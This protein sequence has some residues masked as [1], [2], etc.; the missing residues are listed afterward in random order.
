MITKISNNISRKVNTLGLK[1]TII[2]LLQRLYYSSFRNKRL[3]FTINLAQYVPENNYI[4][5]KVTVSPKPSFSQLSHQEKKA[6]RSH[7][8]DKLLNTFARRLA[9]GNKLFLLY[10]NAK[11]AGASWVYVGGKNKFFIVPLPEK[12]FIILDVFTI[13]KYRRMGTATTN[14][15]KILENMKLQGFERAFISTKEWNFYQKSI[16]KAGFELVGKYREFKIFGQNILI[17]SSD[18]ETNF[19]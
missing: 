13:D 6:L 7:G 19:R 3:F 16:M 12:Q 2:L 1:D 8:G 15:I 17:W 14:L 9:K 10:I 11:C 18:S 5:N 4:N